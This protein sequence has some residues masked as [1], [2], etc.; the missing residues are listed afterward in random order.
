MKTSKYKHASFPKPFI[1]MTDMLVSLNAG[2]LVLGILSA[3]SPD[4]EKNWLR[5]QQE[6]VRIEA[7]AASLHSRAQSLQ[8][9]HQSLIEQTR[10]SS[11][12]NANQNETP[13]LAPAKTIASN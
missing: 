7:E 13:A 11:A 3:T 8:Q 9:R 4:D 5:L 12:K 10:H 6:T 1:S 2:L